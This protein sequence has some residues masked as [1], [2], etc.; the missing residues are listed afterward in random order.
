MSLDFWIYSFQHIWEIVCQILFSASPVSFLFVF[1][2]PFITSVLSHRSLRLCLFVYFFSLYSLCFSLDSFYCSVVTFTDSLFPEVSNLLLNPL[3]VF[4]ISK[5]FICIFYDF[6]LSPSHVKFSLYLF[7]IR[8][9]F[10]IV[11]LMSLSVN[12]ISLSIWAY[13]C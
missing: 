2:R 3:S 6:H 8:N 12:F 10:I 4:F 1:N 13:F 7:D 5:S 9:I 11:V